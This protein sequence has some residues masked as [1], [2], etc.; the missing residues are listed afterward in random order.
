MASPT[1]RTRFINPGIMTNEDLADLGPYAYILFTGLWMIAD[2][3][4]RL[5][6]RPKRIWALVMAVWPECNCEMVENLLENLCKKQML[7]R[8]EVDSFRY[9]AIQN[10]KKHQHP[11]PRE[12]A[13]ELPPPPPRSGVSVR[14]LNGMQKATPRH[15]QGMSLDSPSPSRTRTRTKNGGVD[16]FPTYE[17]PVEDSPP[18]TQNGTPTQRKPPASEPRGRVESQPPPEDVEL[19]RESLT[20]LAHAIRLPPP[21]E[22]ITR[23]ILEAGSGASAVQIHETLVALWKRDKFREMRSWGL[24][25]IVLAQCFRQVA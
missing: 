16:H 5:E 11:H 2:R 8:Y 6:D 15:V 3:E 4:G 7:I 10:W 17:A 22:E 1:K 18:P 23:R 25:P 13:S 21:D 19:L 20:G 12:S 9:I 24:L 14:N